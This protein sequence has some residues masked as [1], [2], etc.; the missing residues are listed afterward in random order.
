MLGQASTVFDDG[1]APVAHRASRPETPPATVIEE[2]H[3]FCVCLVKSR[4]D[5][6]PRYQRF[7]SC[8]TARDRAV[9]VS[10]RQRVLQAA[11]DATTLQLAQ[12]HNKFRTLRTRAT[13]IDWHKDARNA[14]LMIL[15]A[16]VPGVKVGVQFQ[17]Y[18]RVQF[19]RPSHLEII[20]CVC[21]YVADALV[22]IDCV[23][24]DKA[25]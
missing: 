20:L 16:V 11:T 9:K 18:L 4:Y 17:T 12:A 13:K 21:P 19:L 8:K 24:S 14:D 10:L 6:F 2:L 5:P 7:I 22:G 1:P 25:G 23:V 15:E 3:R